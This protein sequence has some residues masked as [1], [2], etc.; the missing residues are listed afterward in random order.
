V[1][2]FG[3]ATFEQTLLVEVYN[4]MGEVVGS[5][6]IMVDAPDI[7]YPGSFEAN[8][9]YTVS[10]AGYGRI[11]VQDISPAFG[12]ISHLSSVEVYLTP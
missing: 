11:V 10:E 7:G 5:Q 8:V 9:S 1:R 2:G 12:G 6:P 3:L 4:E